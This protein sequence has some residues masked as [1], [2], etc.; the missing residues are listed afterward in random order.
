MVSETRYEGE[1]REIQ[2]A[3]D[4][5]RDLRG[6]TEAVEANELLNKEPSDAIIS[7]TYQF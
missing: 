7:F 6:L 3:I 2:E 1:P 4:G 5:V